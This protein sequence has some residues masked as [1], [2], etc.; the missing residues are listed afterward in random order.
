MLIGW[1]FECPRLNSLDKSN[2]LVVVRYLDKYF[3]LIS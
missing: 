3:F 1:V 2:D